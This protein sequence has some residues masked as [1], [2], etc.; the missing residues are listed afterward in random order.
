[1]GEVRVVGMRQEERA[2]FGGSALAQRQTGVCRM[3]VCDGLVVL[4]S[5]RPAVTGREPCMTEYSL[6]CSNSH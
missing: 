3:L 5:C 4:L 1:M 2:A 6:L